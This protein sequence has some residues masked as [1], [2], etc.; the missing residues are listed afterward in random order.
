MGNQLPM[1]RGQ[2]T[3]V[4]IGIVIVFIAAMTLFLLLPTLVDLSESSISDMSASPNQALIATFI[5]LLPVFIV[6][7][8]IVVSI[9][10]ITQPRQEQGG[11]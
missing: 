5:R 3:D 7:A 4:I 10:I 9:R 1:T 6:L 11:F 2:V 8:L